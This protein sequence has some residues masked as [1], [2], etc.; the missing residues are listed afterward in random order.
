MILRAYKF[1]IYPSRKQKIKLLNNFS[2]CKEIYNKLLNLSINNYKETKRSLS[3]YDFNKFLTNKYKNIYSQVKQNV[4]DRVSKSFNNFYRRIK[5]KEKKKGFPRF[6][7]S[8]KSI[9]YPQLG[10]KFL[11]E[12][13]IY[14]SKIGDIQ[15]ILHRIPKGN[16]K[17][18]TIKRNKVDQWFIIFSC[19]LEDKNIEHNSEN[20][21]GIDVGLENFATL[22]DG[23][24]IHNKRFLLKSENKLKKLHKKLSKK[25]K[26]SK[27]MFK[28]KLFL[29]KEYE[30]RKS[31]V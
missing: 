18:M 4:S 30:D 9:T 17:T 15:I 6:K 28:T 24:I 2:T 13:K 12:R 1:R 10:F 16:I 3:K 25:K 26:G 23:N 29:A 11:N 31:V 5:N 21:V 14:V 7:S 8:I 19:E 22:S 20:K 27:N